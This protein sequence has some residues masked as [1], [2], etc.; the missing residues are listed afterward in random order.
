M[1]APAG[2]P[3]PPFAALVRARMEESGVGLRELCRDAGL[4]PSFFSKVLAGK[5]SPPAEEEVLRRISERLGLDAARLV[6]AAGRVPSE[7]RGLWSDPGLF[8]AVDAVLRGRRG[9]AAVPRA[10]W[11]AEPGP[12]RGPAAPRRSAVLEDELL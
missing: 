12:V 6:V 11:A 9:A 1:T 7:W 5:R 8:E 3:T 2:L 10:A 4:D